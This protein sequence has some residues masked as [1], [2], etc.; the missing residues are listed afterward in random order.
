[1][2]KWKMADMKKSDILVFGSNLIGNEYA[3]KENM[4]K[5]TLAGFGAFMDDGWTWVED[6]WGGSADMNPAMYLGFPLDPQVDMNPV[7]NGYK[8]DW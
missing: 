3:E 8:K 4:A 2:I 5:A 1:M 7:D 6:P